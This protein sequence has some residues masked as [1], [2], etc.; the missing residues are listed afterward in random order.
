MPNRSLLLIIS[1]SIAAYKG[2][3]LIRRGRDR[4]YVFTTILTEG[5]QQFITPLS[6][7]S[8][9]GNP[10]YTDLFSLKDETEMGHIRLS[11]ENDAIVVVPASANLL[12]DMVQGV[13][14]DLASTV[15]LATNRPVFVA[16][17]M[18]HKMWDNPATQRNIAQ[19]IAD[20]VHVI[21][22]NAGELAC[23]ETGTGRMAEVHEILDVL[24][25]YFTAN[26]PLAGFKALLTAGPTQE[27]ID[28]VRYISNHSSGKQGYAI[29][30][31]LAEAGADVTLISGPTALAIPEHVVRVDVKTADEMLAACV[32]ALPADIAVCT[33]AVADWKVNAPSQ[34]KLKKH[35]NAPTL[36]LTENADI[37]AALGRHSNRPRLLVGFAAETEN[38]VANAKEKLLKKGCDWVI[39]NDVSAGQV[40]DADDNQVQLISRDAQ[41]NW[42]TL[43]KQAVARELVSRIVDTLNPQPSHRKETSHG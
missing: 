14:N 17:G 19:L 43:S 2:L 36:T 33:A 16:P 25:A 42:P 40:F 20:G 10:C 12:S 13:A 4:G 1:G 9:S 35:G 26:Q 41:E 22:P 32:Q 24:D 37:L 11:R 3:E 7:A 5:G 6:A 29:A 8:L 23:G 38:L 28:P 27:P 15:L 31:A 34:Q 39:A 18:N 30:R 21:Q